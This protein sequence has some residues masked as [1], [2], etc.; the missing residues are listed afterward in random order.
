MQWRAATEKLVKRTTNEATDE[1]V[2]RYLALP[3]IVVEDASALRCPPPEPLQPRSP[4]SHTRQEGGWDV[5]ENVVASL[6][7]A[8]ACL[9]MAGSGQRQWVVHDPMT[10]RV[11]FLYV[12]HGF[13]E[14]FTKAWEATQASVK[15]IRHA[16]DV[17]GA[18]SASSGGD[19]IPSADRRNE[20]GEDS[21]GKG[22]R[23]GGGAK[24]SPTPKGKAKAKAAPAG[25]Q[26]KTAIRYKTLWLGIS[27]QA[28]RLLRL[29]KANEEWAW[30]RSGV[31]EAC[32]VKA[33]THVETIVESS[34]FI[35]VLLTHDEKSCKAAFSEKNDGSLDAG[36][37]LWADTSDAI[38]AV[39]RAVN[40]LTAMH[41]A[42]FGATAR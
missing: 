14:R 32:L 28:H 15:N 19:G 37:K 24:A 40:T 34:E 3:Q 2:G 7:Y 23:R 8:N 27:A 20:Q 6:N 12:Q 22:T 9:Q 29:M 36:M 31:D 25:A 1:S 10:N 5:A 18:A 39:E 4:T 35:Q 30:A 41:K 26:W 33:V 42:R 11:R 21:V 17:A 38:D 13:R 16:E